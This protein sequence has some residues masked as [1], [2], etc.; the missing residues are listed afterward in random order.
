MSKLKVMYVPRCHNQSNF[1]FVVHSRQHFPLLR[2]LFEPKPLNI[3]TPQIWGV[4]FPKWEDNHP[5]KTVG[6]LE[7]TSGMIFCSRGHFGLLVHL[8][9]LQT[10]F[11]MG[12]LSIGISIAAFYNF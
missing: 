4:R 11:Q 2:K 8:P 7:L 12:S 3:F 1:G 5:P 10:T 9:F 6:W